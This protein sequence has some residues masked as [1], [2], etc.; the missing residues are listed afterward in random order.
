MTHSF[1]LRLAMFITSFCIIFLAPVEGQNNRFLGQFFLIFI[2]TF[3][4]FSSFQLF[5]TI[6]RNSV[7]MLRGIQMPPRLP[8]TIP[9]VANPSHWSS[10]RP[11]HSSWH[12]MTMDRFSFGAMR[13]SIEQQRSSPIS[14]LRGVCLS[15]AMNRSSLIMA[16]P[17][18]EWI[19]GHRTERNSRH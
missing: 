8:T 12:V 18:I 2:A 15:S 1:S 14:L 9:S 17:T 6:N 4:R 11:T 10:I 16:S 13:A 3:N 5:H 7:P 19:D